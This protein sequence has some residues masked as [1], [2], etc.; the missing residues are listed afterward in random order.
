[1]FPEFVRVFRVRAPHVPF[2]NGTT[3]VFTFHILSSSY[4][5]PGIFPASSIS[6]FACL[7]Q[8]GL[9]ALL[10]SVPY[11]SLVCLLGLVLLVYLSG[12]GDPT[13]A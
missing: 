8:M 1:M 12:S 9:P 11:L 10:F 13:G 2:T 3:V 4:F 7:H 6:S 5:R